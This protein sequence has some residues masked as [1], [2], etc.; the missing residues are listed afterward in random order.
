M[1]SACGVPDGAPAAAASPA[2]APAV[3]LRPW[4]ELS[5]EEQADVADRAKVLHSKVRWDKPWA[6]IAPHADARTVNHADAQNGNTVIHLAAQ[7]GH[8]HTV[9]LL[10]SRADLACDLDAQNKGGQTALHMAVAYDYVW[11]ARALC[12]AGAGTGLV[13]EEGHASGTGIDGDKAAWRE[14]FV[15][16]VCD[17][18]SSAECL[19]ALGWLRAAIAGGSAVDKAAFAM[20]GMRTKKNSPGMWTDEVNAEF[21]AVLCSI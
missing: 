15:S 17:A 12:T 18:G 16:H 9:E 20:G 8:R 5:P 14:D 2:A 4:E 21:K 3:V 11:I 10:L 19:Q 6:E 13:N 7:N 1:G